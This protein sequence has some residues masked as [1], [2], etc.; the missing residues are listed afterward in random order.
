LGKSGIV[1]DDLIKE[2]GKTGQ[3]VMCLM[4]PILDMGHHLFLDNWYRSQ[5]LFW[6][7]D[8]ERFERITGNSHQPSPTKR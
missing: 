2:V 8:V 7:N 3:I 1:T 5:S 6:W 4:A